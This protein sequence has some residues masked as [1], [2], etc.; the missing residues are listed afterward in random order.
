MLVV[1]IYSLHTRIDFS[2]RYFG[3]NILDCGKDKIFVFMFNTIISLQKVFFCLCN[4]I[5]EAYKV[6]NKR[7]KDKK[8]FFGF[9]S[10][11]AHCR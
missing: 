7:K 1:L 2:G 4:R 11:Y 9:Y 5:I 8:K 3:T 10:C 6:C